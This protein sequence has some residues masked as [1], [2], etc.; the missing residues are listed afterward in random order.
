MCLVT[1]W[2][3]RTEFSAQ[4]LG[5]ATQAVLRRFRGPPAIFSQLGLWH[6]T[7]NSML[8][9]AS[10]WCSWDS[11]IAPGEAQGTNGAGNWT[12]VEYIP[13]CCIISQVPWS[14][15]T[16]LSEIGKFLGTFRQ[17]MLI[18]YWEI[19]SSGIGKKISKQAPKWH[20]RSNR[21]IGP[22]HWRRHGWELST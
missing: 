5:W 18:H 10:C 7:K 9:W 19:W 16:S 21:A 15:L 14:C 3:D 20:G 17:F 2:D 8:L 6:S 12:Q 1:S 11:W 22:L 13:I 4:F